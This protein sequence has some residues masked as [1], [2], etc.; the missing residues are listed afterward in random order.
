[1]T[2]QAAGALF[3]DRNGR[4]LLVQPS[5]KQHWDIPGGIVEEGETPREA[6]GRE[7][8]EELGITADIGRLLI[9][10]HLP[11]LVAYIFDGGY[12]DDTAIRVDGTEII[13]WAWCGHKE[14]VFHTR[15]APILWRRLE[16]AISAARHGDC[17]YLENG[18]S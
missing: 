7:V 11:E 4:V 8:K 1:M 2:R 18:W 17:T 6:A 13:G 12:I 10:D 9:I 3:R 15:T 16:H 14:R 5:Y